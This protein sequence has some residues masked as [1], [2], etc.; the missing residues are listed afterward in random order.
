MRHV[1]EYLLRAL[2]EVINLACDVRRYYCIICCLGYCPEPCFISC[3]NFKRPLSFNNPPELCPDVIHNLKKAF[4]RLD[5]FPCKKL[6][7][8]YYLVLSKKRKTKTRFYF[9]F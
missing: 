1:S 8:T 3:D 9:N 6:Q 2:I 7:Y 5:S 4:I